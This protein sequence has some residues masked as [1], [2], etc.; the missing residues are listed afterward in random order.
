MYSC[1]LHD[2]LLIG[3]T[4]GRVFISHVRPVEMVGISYLFNYFGLS[5]FTVDK[6]R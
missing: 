4:L 3:E 1:K 5:L 2:V 6:L